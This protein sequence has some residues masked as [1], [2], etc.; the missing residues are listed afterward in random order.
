MKT[1]NLLTGILIVLSFVS[2][3]VDNNDNTTP[4]EPAFKAKLLK[5]ITNSD[6]YW[7][8]YF[9]NDQKQIELMTQTSNQIDYDSTYFFYDNGVLTKTLQRV[10]T[11]TDI[12]NTELAYT[13]FNATTAS[14]TY[15]VFKED[16]TIFQNQTFQYTFVNNLV[17]T[18]TFFNLDGTKSSEK[19][20]THDIAGNLTNWTEI[21]YGSNNAI[22]SQKVH[23]FSEWDTDGLKTQSL[24]YWNYRIDNI[25][26]RFISSN[27][28]LVRTENNQNYRYSF[29]YDADG[30]VTKNYSINEGKFITLEYYEE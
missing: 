16:G 11:P 14:G 28:C 21:W 19:L 29:D 6:G 12:I 2:C 15:K 17:K 22:N 7:N 18:I 27:N 5:K 4:E 13:A 23:T 10:Y 8:K 25:P 20:Y 30:N 3:S 9:Y 26:N 1:I 24:L